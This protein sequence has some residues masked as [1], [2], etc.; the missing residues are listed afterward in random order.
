MSV[1]SINLPLFPTLK[2]LIITPYHLIR[3]YGT[4]GVG[5]YDR[6]TKQ[7]EAWVEAA[8]RISLTAAMFF[9]YH[10]AFALGNPLLGLSLVAVN[11]C[12]HPTANIDALCLITFWNA[13]SAMKQTLSFSSTAGSLMNEVLTKGVFPSG[14]HQLY[15]T[16]IEKGSATLSS[17]LKWLFCFTATLAIPNLGIG[18]Q[19]K[20]YS[21][22][23]DRKIALVAK[24][25]APRIVDFLKYKS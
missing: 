14:G 23:L 16:S 24:A 22:W 25:A 5:A 7:S 1:R 2:E 17:S 10:Y 19:I 21:L 18:K 15:L 20:H 4:K 3:N 6:A 9:S 12:I 13:F 11:M 8:C